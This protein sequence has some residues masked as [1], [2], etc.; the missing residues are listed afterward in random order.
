MTYKSNLKGTSGNSFEIG[1]GNDFVID[2]SGSSLRVKDQ[3]L[4]VALRISDLLSWKTISS[5]Q[6]RRI[7]NGYSHI[8]TNVSIVDTGSLVVEDGADLVILD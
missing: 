6:G 5:G 3:E 8:T 4:D 1:K 7:L 2:R